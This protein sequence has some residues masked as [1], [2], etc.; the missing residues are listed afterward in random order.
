[1]IRLPPHD[2]A[3]T[4]IDVTMAKAKI[5][6]T[7][8]LRSNSETNMAREIDLQIFEYDGIPRSEAQQEN[9]AGSWDWDIVND[10]FHMEEEI[11]QIFHIDKKNFRGFQEEF[12]KLAY[13][14]ERPKIKKA[15]EEAVANYQPLNLEYGLVYKR[16]F[17]RLIQHQAQVIL[18]DAG[19]PVRMVGKVE[20]VTGQA[21]RNAELQ[22]LKTCVD[23]VKDVV[24]I[25]S[26]NEGI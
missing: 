11:F 19:N 23:Q 15:L 13:P 6:L 16:K 18:D 24:V 12:V 1:M 7:K 26:L 2:T 9:H 25:S 5:N 10:K 21:I 4:L 8:I 3:F 22:L 17:E 20:D 14:K